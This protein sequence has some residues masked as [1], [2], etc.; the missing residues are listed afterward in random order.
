[1]KKTK[2]F[3]KAHVTLAIMLVALVAAVGLNMKYSVEGGDSKNSS[4]KYLGQADYVNASVDS[5]SA[6]KTEESTYFK[7]LRNDRTKAREE[8]L[9]ILE[10]TLENKELS[11]D[12][13]KA[14]VEKSKALATAAE[15]EGAIE[16]LLKAKGFKNVL[17]VIGEKDVNII[18]DKAP[19]ETAV[20]RIQDAVVSQT[21]FNVAN[22][23][24]ITAE[25]NS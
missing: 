11:E 15:K 10:E 16:T 8:A 22:I 4:S 6:N 7:N 21:E 25:E 24:I 9:D 13:R 3:T 17:A 5:E 19:D 23:K 20:T 1:M 18:V 14:A 2:K 12:E